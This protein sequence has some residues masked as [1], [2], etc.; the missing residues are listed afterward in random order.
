MRAIRAQ[1]VARLTE[2][3]GIGKKTAERIGL[4]LK[5]RLPLALRSRRAGQPRRDR[6]TSCATTCSRRSSISAIS[7][8]VAEKAIDTDARREARRRRSS[9]RCAQA[10]RVHDQG[11]MKG[12]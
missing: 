6:K 9:R 7:A 4:E 3:P 11:M 12:A 1:D 2:I 8:R 5:D 10:L